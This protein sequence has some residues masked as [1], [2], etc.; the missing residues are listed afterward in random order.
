MLFET[1]FRSTCG[2]CSGAVAARFCIWLARRFT[3]ER[4][5]GT[6]P[7]PS[8]NGP[9]PCRSTTGGGKPRPYTVRLYPDLGTAPA[10]SSRA[11][12][13]VVNQKERHSEFAE[14]SCRSHPRRPLARARFLGKL[15][16]TFFF[17]RLLMRG[18]LR[19]FS[20]SC[21]WRSGGTSPLAHLQ[22]TGGS[23]MTSTST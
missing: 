2:F 3:D 22:K 15:G 18:H 9:R 7:R 12:V 1:G 4:M 8:L 19:R 13:I 14:E 21:T 23:L 20:G 6:C 17:I 5:G 10:L 11:Q 16:M